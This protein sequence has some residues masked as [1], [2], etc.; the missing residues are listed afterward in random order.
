MKKLSNLAANVGSYVM[1]LSGRAR[2]RIVVLG[3]LIL[4]GSSL[5]KLVINIQQMQSPMPA[6]TP[7]A[8]IRPM[9]GL[10]RQT[11]REAGAYRQARQQNL[12]NLDS[13]NKMYYDQSRPKR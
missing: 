3:L 7:D 10:I 13:L 8:L 2:L 6:A 1:N 11:S 9:E 4:G 12:K 5:Y